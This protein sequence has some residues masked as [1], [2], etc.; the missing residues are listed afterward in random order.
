VADGPKPARAAARA[1]AAAPAAPVQTSAFP[2]QFQRFTL[3]RF[4]V[5]PGSQLAFAAAK[6]V[7]DNHGQRNASF[8]MNPLFIYGGAGLG[9]THLMIGIGKALQTRHPELAICYLKVDAF[10]HELTSAIK[11]RNTE[12]LRRKYQAF[13]ALLLDDIQTLRTMERTQEE[14][15]YIL[16]HLLQ[17][18]KQIVITSDNPPQR[19]EGL[20]E[21]LITRFKWG[22]TADVQPPDFETRVAILKK[23]LEDADFQ[24]MPTVPEDVVNFIAH[25]AKGSVRDLEGLLNRVIFQ[26]SFLGAPVSLEVAHTAFQ[27]TSGEEPG[28]AIPI[29]RVY[30]MTAETFNV[31]FTDLMKKKSR[32]QSILLPRQVAMY[33]ARELT[34]ASY[35]AIGRSFNMHYSTVMN[36]IDSVKQRMKRDP[37]FHR[38]VESLLNSIH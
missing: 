8:N 32:Q 20:H 12:P 7:V 15:F 16:E 30:R 28:A 25:K 26:A 10:F 14:I 21:R 5:G 24:A 29:D 3:D 9:K 36:A 17:H 1:S 38:M 23:K 2:P 4:V 27:G 19:L 11:V 33:L 22:L 34:A 6:A 37:D 35:P 31:A 18:G 13:D